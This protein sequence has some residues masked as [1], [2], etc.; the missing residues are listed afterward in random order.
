MLLIVNLLGKADTFPVAALD[1]VD[2]ALT[3]MGF[4][5][6]VRSVIRPGKEF[7]TT[8]EGPE[9]EKKL[10]ENILLPI[11]EKYDFDL[12]V[13]TEESVRFP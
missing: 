8:Y 2:A 7:S 10:I 11:A 5:K 12:S 4:K 1:G 13:E 9:K 3:Q 6:E